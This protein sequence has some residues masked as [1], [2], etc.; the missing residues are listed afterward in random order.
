MKKRNF[1]FMSILAFLF[2]GFLTACDFKDAKANFQQ[3]EIVVSV[4]DSVNLYDYLTFENV[5][6]GDISFKCENSDIVASSAGELVALSSGS[7]QVYATYKNNLLSSINVFV[8]GFFDAPATVNYVDGQLIWSPV[9]AEDKNGDTEYA[10]G[11][12]I[13][14]TRTAPDGEV[15]EINEFISSSKNSINFTDAGHYVISIQT[16]GGIGY[17][18]TTK[19]ENAKIYT[20]DCGYMKKLKASDIVWESDGKLSWT[21]VADAKYKVKVNGV[22]LG[23]LQ[24][25]TSY[26]LSETITNGTADEYNISVVVYDA[27]GNLNGNRYECESEQI[28]VSKL[29]SPTILCE[30]GKLKVVSQQEVDEFDF[31]FTSLSGT[32]GIIQINEKCTG[33]EYIDA[34]DTL[35]AGEYFLTVQVKK[36]GLYFSGDSVATLQ[37][38]VKLSKVTIEGTGA[39]VENGTAVNVSFSAGDNASS[40]M[41]V[42][43]NGN[44]SEMATTANSIDFGGTG[45][46]VVKAMQIPDDTN[47][48]Y[49]LNSVESDEVTFTVLSWG[50]DKQITHAYVEVGEDQK[51][52]VSKLSF[53]SVDGASKYT[54]FV[55]SASVWEKV[56][57]CEQNAYTFNGKIENLYDKK[58]IENKLTFKVVASGDDKSTVSVSKE[59]VV[60]VLPKAEE[61]VRSDNTSKTYQWSEVANAGGYLLTI[62]R[63]MNSDLYGETSP[64][65]ENVG[66]TESVKTVTTNSVTLEDFGYYHIEIQSISNDENLYISSLDVFKGKFYICEKLSIS[67]DDFKFGYNSEYNKETLATG[68]ICHGYFIQIKNSTA[69]NIVKYAVSL[70]DGEKTESGEIVKSSGDYTIYKFASDF[71]GSGKTYTISIVEKSDNVYVKTSDTEVVSN[72]TYYTKTTDNNKDVYTIVTSPTVENIGNYYE[73]YTKC[74]ATIYL[75]SDAVTKTV[76]RLKNVEISDIVVGQLNL[77]VSSSLAKESI[78]QS[79]SLKS[80]ENASTSINCG[81]DFVTNGSYDIANISSGNNVT[82]QYIGSRIKSNIYEVQDSTIYLSGESLA[83]A[84][85]RIVTPTSLKYEKGELHFTLTSSTGVNATYYRVLISFVDE[86]QRVSRIDVCVP[87]ES[88]EVTAEC[89]GTKYSLGQLNCYNFGDNIVKINIT[90]ILEKIQENEVLGSLYTQAKE[91]GFSA[92]CFISEGGETNNGIVYNISSQFATAEDNS[93]VLKVEKL[94]APKLS[95]TYA[96]GTLTFNWN[97]VSAKGDT[98][99]RLYTNG[100]VSGSCTVTKLV[101]Q[102]GSDI[103]DL[104]PATQYIFYVTAIN[105]LYLES[106]RS[107]T[108]TIYKLSQIDAISLSDGKIVYQLKEKDYASGVQCTTDAGTPTVTTESCT[109]VGKGTY[110]LSVKGQEKNVE[111]EYVKTSDTSV[112]ETKTYYTLTN[113]EYIAVTS[114]AVENI[115]NYYEKYIE[116]DAT[117]YLDSDVTIWTVEEMSELAPTDNK[118]SF[119]SNSISWQEF[120]SG[121]TL[122]VEYILY[123][124]DINEKIVSYNNGKGASVDLTTSIVRENFESLASGD[125]EIF[126]VAKLNNYSVSNGSTVQTIYF[127]NGVKLPNGETANN[128][129]LYTSTTVRK[130]EAPTVTSVQFDGEDATPNI[131][132]T[133]T[134]NF[135]GDT[136]FDIYFGG[137]QIDDETKDED[138]ATLFEEIEIES[139]SGT[140]NSFSFTVPYARYN[141]LIAGGETKILKISADSASQFPSSSGSVAISRAESVKN[142]KFVESNGKLT[143]NV[144]IELTSSQFTAGGIALEITATPVSGNATT[145]VVNID[146]SQIV[147]NS[148]K[149]N[150]DLST[151]L[152]KEVYK[153]CQSI[154]LNARLKCFADDANK[155]YILSSTYSLMDVVTYKIIPCVDNST[156]LKKTSSGFTIDKTYNDADIS[157][158]EIQYILTVTKYNDGK[159]ETERHNEFT[160]TKNDNEKYEFVFPRGAEWESGT[161]TFEIQTVYVNDASESAST[162]NLLDSAKSTFTWELTRLDIIDANSISCTRDADNLSLVTMS[163]NV[164]N[165]AKEYVVEVVD[166]KG[167]TLC[168]HTITGTTT[169]ASCSMQDMIQNVEY[170]SSDIQATVSIYAKS[171]LSEGIAVSFPITIRANTLISEPASVDEN[172]VLCL[173]VQKG[174]TYLYR[175]VNSDGDD[176][177]KW[178]KVTA[179]SDTVKIDTNALTKGVNWHVEIAVYGNV[180][181]NAVNPTTANPAIVADSKI[182]VATNTFIPTEKICS[183]ARNEQ[184]GNKNIMAVEAP[185]EFTNILVGLSEDAVMT[186]EVASIK[187]NSI[188]S[189]KTDGY[190]IYGLALG[191]V[192]SAFKT[193]NI[194]VPTSNDPQTMWLW[195]YKESTE[196]ARYI[197]S[198]SFESQFIYMEKTSITYQGTVKLGDENTEKFADTYVKFAGDSTALGIYVRIT[199]YEKENNPI[200]VLKFCDSKS[201]LETSKDVFGDANNF[202]INLT[203]LFEKKAGEGEVSLRDVEGDLTI[204]YAK[205]TYSTSNKLFGLN[206]WLGTDENGKEFGFY[207]LS[208]PGNVKLSGGDISWTDG[209]PKSSRYY[210]YFATQLNEDQDDLESASQYSYVYTQKTSYSASEYAGI[211]QKYHIAVQSINS[212][213]FVLSS[214][215]VFISKDDAITEIYRNQVSGGLEL[216]G[217]AL[218]FKLANTEFATNLVALAGK[219]ENASDSDIEDFMNE[220]YQA[221]FTF[222]ISDLFGDNISVRLKFTSLDVETN[223]KYQ[224]FDVKAKYLLQNLF[225]VNSGLE[226]KL[227]TLA[228]K[229]SKLNSIRD[230]F[231]RSTGGIATQQLICDEIFNSLSIGNYSIQYQILGGTNTLN[232]YW[233]DFCNIENGNRNIIYINSQPD[234]TI[235]CETDANGNNKYS[236]TFK[237]TDVVSGYEN[238]YTLVENPVSEKIKAYFEKTYVQTS[239]TGIVDGKTYYTKT[240][241]NDK[242]VYT[243]VESPT[244]GNISTYYEEEYTLT[245][246]TEISS[247]KEYYELTSCTPIMSPATS[248]VMKLYTS[249]DSYYTFDFNGIDVSGNATMKIG[250]QTIYSKDVVNEG[251]V[252]VYDADKDGNTTDKSGNAIVGGGYY[253]FYLNCVDD[254]LLGVFGDLIEKYSYKMQIYA[255]GTDFSL[256]SKSQCFNV[257]FLDFTGLSLEN[258]VLSWTSVGTTKVWCNSSS[259]DKGGTSSYIGTLTAKDAINGRQNL[260]VSKMGAGKYDSIQFQEIGGVYSESVDV[261]SVIYQ[262]DNV[263]KYSAPTVSTELGLIKIDSTANDIDNIFSQSG[264]DMRIITTIREKT[265]SSEGSGEEKEGGSAELIGNLG[266][267]RSNDSIMYNDVSTSSSR[268]ITQSK[269]YEVGGSSE[270]ERTEMT[271]TEF[272]VATV[273][274]TVEKFAS[275]TSGNLLMKLT[276]MIRFDSYTYSENGD[277]KKLTP[278]QNPE[279]YKLSQLKQT[280]SLGYDTVKYKAGELYYVYKIPEE[281]DTSKNGYGIALQSEYTT[282]KAKMLDKSAISNLKFDK[283]TGMLTWENNS[284]VILNDEADFVYKIKITQ[285]Y[286][287]TSDQ[288]ESHEILCIKYFYTTKEYFDFINMKESDFVEN[289]ESLQVEIQAFAGQKSDTKPSNG[290][291]Y[292]SLIEGGYIFGSATYMEQTVNEDGVTTNVDSGIYVLR[293][294]AVAYSG[295]LQKTDSIKEDTLAV[296]SGDLTWRFNAVDGS[297]KYTFFVFDE[298]GQVVD[299]EFSE[300]QKS[301]DEY[302]VVFKDKNGSITAKNQILTVYALKTDGVHFKSLGT[303]IEVCKLKAVQK[304]DVT[305]RNESNYEVIDLTTFFENNQYMKLTS[306]KEIQSG[307]TYY[308]LADG[309]YTAVDSP[310]KDDIANYYEKID[311]DVEVVMTVGGREKFVMNADNPTVKVLTSNDGSSGALI[312][313][314]AESFDLAFETRNITVEGSTTNF[315]YSDVN[316]DMKIVRPAWASEDKITWNDQ[317]KRFEWEFNGEQPLVESGK[318][319]RVIMNEDKTYNVSEETIERSAGENFSIV[320]K[321]DDKNYIVKFTSGD[322]V[323]MSEE[324]VSIPIYYVTATYTNGDSTETRLY[325][326]T[327]NYFVPTIVGDVAISIRVKLSGVSLQS[328]MLEYS[329]EDEDG[330]VTKTVAY[331]LYTS[332]SGTNDDPYIIGDETQFGNIRYKMSERSDYLMS[333]TDES[334][335]VVSEKTGIYYFKLNND[336]TL[337]AFSGVMFSGD[338]SGDIDGDGKQLTYTIYDSVDLSKSVSV[339]NTLAFE[340]QKSEVNYSSGAS[341]FENLTKTAKIH[342]LKLSVTFSKASDSSSLSGDGNGIYSALAITNSGVVNNVNLVGYNFASTDGN[343]WAK[344]GYYQAYAGLVGKNVN[345]GTAIIS[346]CTVS[347]DISLTDYGVYQRLYLSGIVY[348][349]EATVTACSTATDTTMSFLAQGSGTS[350]GSPIQMSALVGVN[351]S[352]TVKDCTNN[353]S[354]NIANNN[355]SKQISAYV[356]TIICNLNNGTSTGNH[357]NGQISS[358]EDVSLIDE[359]TNSNMYAKVVQS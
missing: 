57:D 349:N 125:V 60:D 352:G 285:T 344:D 300:E 116:S 162:N 180:D 126:V 185:Q 294:E 212:D 295:Q 28:V 179:E 302:E 52:D 259:T 96:N 322:M 210:V 154:Q 24:T 274:S 51:V 54:L 74:D 303:K 217:G 70:S 223:G 229:T 167:E 191:D 156:D 310:T 73:K 200:T 136:G 21:A 55:K 286:R 306:D 41:Q 181:G 199:A 98:T 93:I 228:D 114:P 140:E 142:V 78:S 42:S 328:Q 255:V 65:Y 145:E 36:N 146:C 35:S 4:G 13:S 83:V 76:E 243:V 290:S 267:M 218:R 292:Q 163:W 111:Y 201:M 177:K 340:N 37:K 12:I 166:E 198:P 141:S 133:F 334:G 233:Y 184:E 44:A 225:D 112:D 261:D 61:V 81:E 5:E 263:Y 195:I 108:L 132:V 117:I 9:Y 331:D 148:L 253:K 319:A 247:E 99:Y 278:K 49:A 63:T 335:E 324:L 289:A 165:G 338:F 124:K 17:F 25:E 168:S 351:N 350:G 174:M 245:T 23:N 101:K 18:D 87:P 298:N 260:P 241:D 102:F 214:S 159:T 2:G 82:F 355:S 347:C 27:N 144:E 62:Y 216:V 91:V 333:Y 107:N 169:R 254:S 203:A 313:K 92:S 308:T 29:S 150:Y 272:N 48:A 234:Y 94:V 271:A 118:V 359:Y 296:A 1:A 121:K 196:N 30:N 33:R 304:S 353:S 280:S 279:Y 113:G 8:R 224:T 6:K 86:N 265:T 283:Q 270:Y 40:K 277:E 202:A 155:T 143:K 213:P 119:A 77:S 358:G 208:K 341:L 138:G 47:N 190:A 105:D 220:T 32:G 80:I 89:A 161:Y 10:G 130:L 325:E 123:F 84:F 88:G 284:G 68:G 158:K 250:A 257:T 7:S 104:K 244:V 348:C 206:E 345:S 281:E 293:S 238:V 173:S 288:G 222:K 248:Y 67:S 72:K 14:G 321:Y 269:T 240:T 120:A 139:V 275:D 287:S 3:E 264:V 157:S 227:K 134:G 75:D 316:E 249:S 106:S 186:G 11:Y 356:A 327:E 182:L 231:S 299:G 236:V 79:L 330:N 20:F 232:S 329:S 317:K 336:I 115:E 100:D 172:G 205:L 251:T 314:D 342:D 26:N 204:E 221:P 246:D 346:N 309:K 258:G 38:I 53:D 66:W 103:S 90:T 332:G 326:T 129:Y 16:L 170:I 237:K 64:N 307:K 43:I 183:I 122:N 305:I 207:R 215:R 110:K 34:F 323:L 311:V 19:E 320:C 230:F 268:L 135:T 71:S 343:Y 31:T 262:L 153:D 59:K 193:A 188:G 273:G 297:D 211:E 357:D 176:V 197:V 226:G 178:T 50:E 15:S 312:V 95:Y 45:T 69:E 252:T 149:L 175:I 291:S 128:V 301:G 256:S 282:I 266:K 318:F 85:K 315:L 109:I 164:V 171:D 127:A 235:R 239:D 354:L 151:I 22:E 131:V 160:I 339:N 337:S 46:Y 187:V 189:S 147:D 56:G 97:E 276:P 58:V 209:N 137:V 242:D 219:A 194:D 192:I 152:N 39:N